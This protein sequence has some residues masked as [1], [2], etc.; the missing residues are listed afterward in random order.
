[1]SIENIT[2]S[3]LKDA[4]LIANG[5]ITNAEKTKQE[6][7][8][9]ANLEAEELINN[10]VEKSKKEAESLKGRR[11]SAAELQGRKMILSAKQEAIK[12]SFE[13]AMNKLTKMQEDKYLDYMVNEILK[14]SSTE[15]EIILN[16]KDNS[17]IGEK[18]VATINKKANSENFI[19][20]KDTVNCSGGFIFRNGSIEFNNTFETIL[21]AKK[22]ELTNEVAKVLFK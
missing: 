3:I 14:T 2:A 13:V 10:E 15:G 6:I 1:M 12:K 4:E 18:L 8:N 5:L 11:V 7:I 20:S 17:S 19:L 16:K 21:D 22:D 9:K